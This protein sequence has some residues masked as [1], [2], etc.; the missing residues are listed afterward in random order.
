[1]TFWINAGIGLFQLLCSIALAVLALYIGFAVFNRITPDIDEIRELARGNAAIGILVAAIFLGVGLVVQSGIQGIVIGIGKASVDGIFTLEGI[2]DILLTVL[3]LVLGVV[4][5]IGGI[6]LSLRLYGRL[7]GEKEEFAAIRNGNIAAAI[8][9][10]GMILSI[11]V[12]IHSGVIG[13]TMA[14]R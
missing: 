14:I 1:M 8:V 10:A 4:L 9:L 3:Q 7:T 6:Y 12:I 13:I 11:A 5:A 2:T